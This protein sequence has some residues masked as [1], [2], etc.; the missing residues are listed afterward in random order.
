MQSAFDTLGLIWDTDAGTYDAGSGA[1]PMAGLD[2]D[3]LLADIEAW[4]GRPVEHDGGAEADW[5]C[6][7]AAVNAAG[8]MTLTALTARMQER[9]MDEAPGSETAEWGG[10]VA[11]CYARLGVAPWDADADDIIV[12]AGM[13][14][15]WLAV[16]A[17]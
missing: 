6:F 17:D 10:Y 7:V 11:D 3:S 1:R 9:E 15:H 14:S 13:A 8:G 12:P 5:A 16:C 4:R 2:M